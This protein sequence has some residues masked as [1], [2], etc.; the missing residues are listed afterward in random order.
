MK[1]L[2]M[3]LAILLNTID[4]FA[5]KEQ[6]FASKF[7]EINGEMQEEL[8]WNTVSPFMMERIMKLDTLED[9][10]DVRNILSQLKSIQIVESKQMALS[11]SL[12]NSA[13]QL[14]EQ[15]EKRYKIYTN[16]EER[17]IYLRKRNKIIVEMV[18]IAKV[19]HVFSLVS[20]TGNMNES[21]LKE[22]ANM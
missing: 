16:D 19:N 3:A 12:F 4:A 18:F 15:N 9:N 2:L 20:L 13:K 5:Q 10:N 21:F 8:T 7:M 22:L 14:A 1:L 17:L 11:D 6:D